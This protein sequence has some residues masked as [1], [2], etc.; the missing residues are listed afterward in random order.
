MLLDGVTLQKL[1]PAARNFFV[2]AF[3]AVCSLP[4]AAQSFLDNP[5]QP[6]SATDEDSYLRDMDDL[7]HARLQREH[8]KWGN[9]QL[10][11]EILRIEANYIRTDAPTGEI[12]LHEA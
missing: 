4:V 2:A 7:M 10:I 12:V 6:E 1:F 9:K 3:L 5:S 11:P 8:L